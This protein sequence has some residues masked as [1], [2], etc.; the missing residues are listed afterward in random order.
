MSANASLTALTLPRLRER[1]SA[2]QRERMLSRFLA[3]LLAS[4]CYATGNFGFLNIFD[5]RREAQVVLIILTLPFAWVIV[6]R[7]AWLRDPVWW[8]AAIT[9]IGEVVIRRNTLVFFLFDRIA[10]VFVV[11]LLVSLSASF[12][13]LAL[14]ALI[15]L[16]AVFASMVVVQAAAVWFNADVLRWFVLG[17]TTSTAAQPIALGHSLEY[18]G[19]TTPGAAPF[20]GHLFTRFRSFTS[21]PSVVI[22]AFYAPGILALTF[23]P[24]VRYLAIPILAF[25]AGLS[26]SGTAFFSVA[27]GLIG[28]YVVREYLRDIGTPDS[29]AAANVEWA[30]EV[31]S[32]GEF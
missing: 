11:A 24:P 3:L 7:R 27:L 5:A 1:S 25:A 18:L 16:C 4:W 30:P 21:E 19:F 8:L 29:Y 17:Y 22:C 13:E 14:S 23:P 6:K 20:F 10:T 12:S 15:A 26:G 32:G 9:L 28:A 2:S 31:R